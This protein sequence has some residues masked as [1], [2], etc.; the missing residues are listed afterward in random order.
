MS[1]LNV[2][3]KQRA[4]LHELLEEIT[5]NS[6]IQLTRKNELGPDLSFEPGLVHF[7][8]VLT[9][10]RLL[11]EVNLEEFPEQRLTPLVNLARDLNSIL[12][13]IKTFSVSKHRSDPVDVRDSLIKSLADGYPR[14]FDAI[15]PILAYASIKGTD[16]G[17]LV[18]RAN[19]AITAIQAKS[20]EH[21]DQL[22]TFRLDAEGALKAVQQF[23]QEAGVAQHA[24]HF[25]KEAD[26]HSGQAKPWL[27]ATCV[28]AGVTLLSGLGFLISYSWGN[29]EIT[30]VQ[31]LQLTLSKV[32]IASILISATLWTGKMYRAHRHNE[33]INRHRQNA[34][35]TFEAFAKAT[36]DEQTKNAV[37]LQATQCIFAAQQTGYVPSDSDGSHFS[38]I[39]EIVRG[40]GTR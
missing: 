12:D 18:H 40:T 20:K 39:F 8:R 7:Q 16:L 2:E 21:L 27:I 36:S 15:T 19:E 10:Y 31:G 25:K 24:I 23:A 29:W 32:V 17:S 33:I 6:E 35:A 9:L 13:D 1:D 22:Q 5:S 11:K 28:F 26:L 37:L 38:Q 30:S 3:E 14:H 34:L 4:A